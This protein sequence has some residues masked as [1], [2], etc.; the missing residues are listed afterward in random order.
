[1]NGGSL[2]VNNEGG[3]NTNIYS[4]SGAL[5]FYR[6]TTEAARIDA[7]GNFLISKPTV[8][9]YATV[10]GQEFWAANGQMMGTM[11]SASINLILSHISSA[12]ANAVSY[13][14]FNRTG[15]NILGNI[16]QVST[17][18]VNYGNTSHGPFKGNIQDLDDDAALERLRSWRPVSYQW[19]LDENGNYD[20]RVEPSGEEQ[21]G[22][23]AQELAVVQPTA[24]V[25]G[26]G[27]EDGHRAWMA[28]VEVHNAAVAENV[29]DPP[30]EPGEDPFLP[31]M[32]D[33]AKLVPDLTAAVQALDRQ[34]QALR[35]QEA[36]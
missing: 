7:S 9:T 34:V 4:G 11:D 8:N 30:E 3:V 32:V 12:D 29:S 14:R 25:L 5:I 33:F 36:A 6:N 13:V 15:N 16:T 17:T 1:M 19:R 31:G 22:F 2:Y 35:N 23:I 20:E 18:G 10:V 28:A 24:V 21:H 27:T 26:Y